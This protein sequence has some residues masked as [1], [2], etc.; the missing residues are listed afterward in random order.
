MMRETVERTREGT[1]IL[2]RALAALGLLAA[3]G[4]LIGACGPG[5]PPAP[6][7][8]TPRTQSAPAAEPSAERG[9][10]DLSRDEA[11]GGHTLERHV[12]RSDDQLVDRLSREPGVSAASTYADRATAERVV[13]QTLA[14]NRERIDSWLDRVG[15]RPNLALVSPRCSR[16]SAL[17]PSPW[18]SPLS[19]RDGTS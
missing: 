17:R 2:R 10:Y 6:S 7:S 8:E 3:T 19:C 4:M 1:G 5:G 14:R 16:S 12:G 9:R 13:E 11:R 15:Y 18:F